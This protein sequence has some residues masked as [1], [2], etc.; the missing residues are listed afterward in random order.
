MFHPFF[1]LCVCILGNS[2]ER[3]VNVLYSTCHVCTCHVHMSTCNSAHAHATLHIPERSTPLYARTRPIFLLIYPK[4]S[5]FSFVGSGL[6]W[7]QVLKEYRKQGEEDQVFE[8]HVEGKKAAAKKRATRRSACFSFFL[9]TITMTGEKLT[10]GLGFFLK[11]F[12]SGEKE[13]G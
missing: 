5:H 10:D 6:D 3:C 1:F 12:D 11:T 8:K 2:C 7:S 13:T 9:F 4:I